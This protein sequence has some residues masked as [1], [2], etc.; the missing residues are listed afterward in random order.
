MTHLFKD[1]RHFYETKKK[2]DNKIKNIKMQE[3]GL[4]NLT[5]KNKKM[6]QDILLM[7]IT[8]V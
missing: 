3:G 2:K 1:V 6:Y 5:A 8:D 7:K 4:F